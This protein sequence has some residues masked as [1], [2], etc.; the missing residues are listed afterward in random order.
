MC[1]SLLWISMRPLSQFRFKRAIVTKPHSWPRAGNTSGA[2][3]LLAIT[4]PRLYFSVCF[5]AFS[6]D[7]VSLPSAPIISMTSLSFQTHLTNMC[8]I[9]VALLPPCM[10]M[11]L[12]LILKNVDSPLLLFRIWVI[13]SVLI[14]LNLFRIIWLPT[15]RSRKNVRQFLGK[16]NFYRKF[17]PNST[18]LLEPFHHLLRKN[19]PFSWSPTYQSSFDKVKRLLASEPILAVFDRTKPIFIYTDASTVGIGAVLKQKQADGSEKPVAYF[20]KKLSESQSKRK[21][22]KPCHSGGNPLLAFLADGL[23]VYS[24][25]WP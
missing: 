20:S 14:L 22:W 5:R 19:D 21:A 9:F 8:H 11:G 10:R 12:A 23:S 4:T 3:C 15:P 18:A 17:I 25:H 16:A 13:F 2:P 1:G 6:I 7:A 24:H